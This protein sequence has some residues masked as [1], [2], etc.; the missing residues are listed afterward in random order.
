MI[1]ERLARRPLAPERLYRPRP[2]RLLPLI[3]KFADPDSRCMLP[4]WDVHC[5]NVRRSNGIWAPCSSADGAADQSVSP[6]SGITH[7]PS[8]PSP[9]LQAEVPSAAAVARCAPSDCQGRSFSMSNLRRVI[10]ASLRGS[11][12]RDV[13]GGGFQCGGWRP[14]PKPSGARG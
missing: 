2:G 1:G 13:S 10:S 14:S 3:S 6:Q 12:D 5:K 11:A 7:P 4:H 8:L 9:G